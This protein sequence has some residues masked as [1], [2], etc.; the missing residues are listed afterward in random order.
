MLWAVASSAFVIYLYRK[1]DAEDIGAV[2][3]AGSPNTGRASAIDTELDRL[4]A[5]ISALDGK[6]S[7]T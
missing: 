4:E 5:R 6:L 7:K 3:P 2:D 1:L